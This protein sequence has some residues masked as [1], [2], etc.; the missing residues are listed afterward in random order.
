MWSGAKWCVQCFCRT[1]WPVDLGL[2]HPSLVCICIFANPMKCFTHTG[3]RQRSDIL[4]LC[5]YSISFHLHHPPIWHTHNT[6]SLVAT[7]VM[8]Q[9]TWWTAPPP[10]TTPQYATSLNP[11][12][13]SLRRSLKIWWVSHSIVACSI[14]GVSYACSNLS[15][16]FLPSPPSLL[17]THPL[18]PIHQDPQ[19]VVDYHMHLVGHGDSGSGCHLHDSVSVCSLHHSAII[20]NHGNSQC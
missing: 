9:R 13:P 1:F 11:P 18:S 7:S 3:G 10:L 6:H 4:D 16:Q 5:D 19:E 14:V 20:G 15:L 17:P 12:R 2:L 8:S